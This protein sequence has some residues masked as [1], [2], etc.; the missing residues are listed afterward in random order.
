MSLRRLLR[1]LPVLL[2]VVAAGLASCERL[3]VGPELAAELGNGRAYASRL[4][5]QGRAAEAPSD[6]ADSTVIALTYLERLRLGLGSPFRLIELARS[7]PRLTDSARAHLGWALLAS[8]LDGR[9]Y[10]I[11]PAVFTHA[12]RRDS[13]V[14]RETAASHLALVERAVGD[15]QDPRAGEL[16]VRLAYTLAASEHS[17]SR[18]APVV[19]ARVAALARDRL[20]ARDDALAL[21][22]AARAEHRDPLALITAWRAGRRFR[23]ERAPMEPLPAA[24]QREA[25]DAAPSVLESIRNLAVRDS[26]LTADTSAV[27]QDGEDAASIRTAAGPI[28]E[29]YLS[30]AAAARAAQAAARFNAPPQAPIVVAIASYRG[31]LV[32]PEGLA[33]P[34]RAERKRFASLARNEESFAAEYDVLATDTEAGGEI[35]A[36]TALSA[37]VAMRAYAQ[38]EIWLP[39]WPGPSDKEL[40]DRFGLAAV[41]F[42]RDVPTDWRPYYRRMI[43]SALADMQRVIPSLTVSGLHI[44][45]GESPLGDAALAFHDPASRTLFLPVGTGA[46]T[47][48]HEVA[49][50]LDWQVARARYHSRAQYATDRAIR[51]ASG[52]LATSLRGLTT[53]ALIPPLPENNYS[54]PHAQRPAEVFARSVDWLVA[55]SLAREGRTNGYLSSVQ[56]DLLTGY[57]TVTPPDITGEAGRALVNILD[58]VSPVDDSMR[59]WF[60][61]RYGTG[62][63]LTPYDL[64][65]RISE[66]SVRLQ[67]T[68][69]ALSSAQLLAPLRAA[70]DSAI[71]I[72]RQ[73]GCRVGATD[74][75]RRSA[76]ARRDL[77]LLATEA[78]GEGL[79][80]GAA[81]WVST[82]D[83]RTFARLAALQGVVWPVGD[84]GML[85]AG[86]ASRLA[87]LDDALAALHD[88]TRDLRRAALRCDVPQGVASSDAEGTAVRMTP[89]PGA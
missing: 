69:A 41:T 27:G 73:E 75:D 80:R 74:D 46:G 47:L 26:V 16:A 18:G 71:D 79:V 9:S 58:D 68:G 53:A 8:T 89:H 64:V 1:S 28:A 72:V 40:R 3:S 13:A 36:L 49:H 67:P 44:H 56:D 87:A 15:A 82:R 38:E 50:D 35:P 88:E 5:T 17:A 52:P 43:A 4:I 30:R 70:R 37:A 11:D 2:A 31:N 39:G 59:E 34:Q 20:L 54:P 66:V 21:L 45:V 19:A 84:G 76:A 22:R 55:V 86:L 78:R 60:L 24:V 63:A 57:V 32:A 25:M 61:T 48:A 33:Y 7:D 83:A 6:V 12:A 85:T 23:V 65:R 77:V 42:D 29:P 51:D 10:E 14:A 81:W 62:R